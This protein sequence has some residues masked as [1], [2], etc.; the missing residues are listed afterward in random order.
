MQFGTKSGAL[1]QE[2]GALG[3]STH[4]G[5]TSEWSPRIAALR[6][7]TRRPPDRITFFHHVLVGGTRQ[8]STSVFGLAPWRSRSPSNV[9]ALGHLH[10]ARAVIVCHVVC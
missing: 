4:R 9:P 5:W 3:T 8:P 7:S 10:G 1:S 2:I 6:P